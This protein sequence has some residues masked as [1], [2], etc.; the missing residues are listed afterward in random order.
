M[1]T[2]KVSQRSSSK[3]TQFTIL[4]KVQ[5]PLAWNIDAS[6]RRAAVLLP[7]TWIGWFSRKVMCLNQENTER[8]GLLL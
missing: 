5:G 7:F 3:L 6:L 8:N 1:E 4:K 2:L